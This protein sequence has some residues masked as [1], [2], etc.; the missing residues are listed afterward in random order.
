MS[1]WNDEN[2]RADATRQ[3]CEMLD[4]DS[5]LREACKR[6]KKT[7]WQTLKEAGNFTDMPTDIEVYVFENEVESSDKMVTL[8]LPKQ[9]DVPSGDSFNPKSVWLCTWSRYLQ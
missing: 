5:A 7:A 4:A 3:F 9:G 6:D 1:E 8:V 2:A